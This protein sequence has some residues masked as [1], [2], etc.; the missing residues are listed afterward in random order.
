LIQPLSQHPVDR[1]AARRR[2]Q[3]QLQVDL[4]RTPRHLAAM[5]DQARQLSITRRVQVALVAWVVMAQIQA[6]QVA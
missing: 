3:L 2:A 1:V 5:V 6:S 4:V